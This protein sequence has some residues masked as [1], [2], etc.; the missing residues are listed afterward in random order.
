MTEANVSP[1]D[2]NTLC[3]FPRSSPSIVFRPIMNVECGPRVP[4]RITGGTSAESVA[5]SSQYADRNSETNAAEFAV[6]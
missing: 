3:E 5:S 2:R 1:T 6:P 4:V